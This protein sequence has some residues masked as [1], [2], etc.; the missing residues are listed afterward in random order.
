MLSYEYCNPPSGSGCPAH[1][2]IASNPTE[3]L[4]ASDQ[5]LTTTSGH[6][7][8]GSSYIVWY[9]YP[10][11]T[12]DGA[13]ILSAHSDTDLLL[14]TD[15]ASTWTMLDVGQYTGQSRHLLLF[16]DNGTERLH[17]ATAG[18]YD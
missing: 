4:N 16:N 5:T 8:R 18:S 13:V 17:L 1:Y 12:T 10:D 7:P 6:T 15:N 9:G 2:R 14:S 11:S 3:F